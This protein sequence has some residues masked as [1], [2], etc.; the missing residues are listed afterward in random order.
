MKPKKIQQRP[1]KRGMSKRI[2]CA[3]A[4]LLVAV[5]AWF[6]FKKPCVKYKAEEDIIPCKINPELLCE[7]DGKTFADGKLKYYE[8]WYVWKFPPEACHIRSDGRKDCGPQELGVKTLVKADAILNTSIYK[9]G[10]RVYGEM[11]SDPVTTMSRKI[12]HRYFDWGEQ[13]EIYDPE[14]TSLLI[15]DC[16]WDEGD[17]YK[18]ERLSLVLDKDGKPHCP[19]KKPVNAKK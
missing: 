11:I 1:A 14:E 5:G 8:N 6:V 7:K 9:K 17:R 4:I 13:T 10:K 15:V 19:V 16:G 2:I 3:V 18:G 12:V